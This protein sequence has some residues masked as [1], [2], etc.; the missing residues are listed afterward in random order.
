V[1]RSKLNPADAVS[2]IKEARGLPVLA[3]PL[4]VTHFL[5]SLIEQ[6][7]VGLEVYYNGYSPED[8]RELADLGHKYDLIPTGG[9]DFHGSGV[10]DTVGVGGVRVPLESVERLRALARVRG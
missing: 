7:L 5:P 2:L 4:K 6:G 9:S 8:I 10:L 3:H 1:E